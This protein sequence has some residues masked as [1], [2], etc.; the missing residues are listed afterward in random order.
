MIREIHI[1]K[2]G[3]TLFEDVIVPNKDLDTDAVMM[4]VSASAKKL[5]EWKIDSMEIERYRYVYMN[6]HN[7]QFIITMDRQASLQKVN[8]AMMSMVSKFM[9]AFENALE[10]DEWKSTD[11]SPFGPG[12]RQIVS[13]IPVK[14]CLAGHG[15]TG[16]TTLLELATLPSR[17]PP[18][19]Y[20]PT[21]FGDKALLKADFDPYVF[22]MFDLGGQDRFVQE[23]GKIIRSGSMVVVVTDSTEENLAWTRRVAY[24]VLRNELPYARII[25]VANK[26]DLPGA[27]SPEEVGRRLGVPAYGMQANRSDFRERWLDLLK[28][29]AFENIEFN[30]V[31][32]IAEVV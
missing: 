7:T 3:K 30:V 15:G 26:Q 17:G 4:L 12:F 9:T 13:R 18:Q 19:E 21:F 27:L 32:E 22:S 2:D 11:F 23:W 25:A 5:Q 31:G 29:L 16:K 20:V 14:V 1:F 24:P 10:S 6:S 28:N 8:E